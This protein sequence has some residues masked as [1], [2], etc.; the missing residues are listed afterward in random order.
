MILADRYPNFSICGL[1]FYLSGEIS[2]WK[3][4]AHRT[5]DE[6]E[7]Q[8]IQLC[9]DHRVTADHPDRKLC[10]GHRWGR[11]QPELFPTTGW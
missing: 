11:S 2:D 9:P 7:E 4:L 1:P 6:I 10:S 3:T 5:I 8:G